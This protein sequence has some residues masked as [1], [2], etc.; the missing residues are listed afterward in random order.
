MAC[1]IS[2]LE[3]ETGTDI[4][5]VGAGPIGIEMALALKSKNFDYLHF[6]AGPLASTISWYSPGTSIFSSPERLAIGEIPFSVYPQLK[7][8]RED[9]LNYLRGVVHQ[10]QP[11]IHTF[12]RIFSV[13]KRSDRTFT[14]L[15][16]PS[17]HGVGGPGELEY[18]SN[19]P[20]PEKENTR[21]VHCKRLILAIGNMHLP[22]VLSI[23]GETLPHVSHFL[24]D[25]H[26]YSGQRVAIVGAKNS[27]AE[28]AIRLCQAH[29]EVTICHR[30]E[31]FDSARVKPWLMPQLRSLQREKRIRFIPFVVPS[32]IEVGSLMLRDLAGKAQVLAC[33]RV[34]LLT[35]YRQN[36]QLFE[37]LGLRLLAETKA[38]LH[39][40]ISMETNVPGV[41][42]AGTAV[43]GT[44]IGGAKAFIE[45]SHIHV[46]KIMAALSG[47]KYTES[48]SSKK[49]LRPEVDWET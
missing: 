13:Q 25:V 28:A 45:T 48:Q 47:T 36:P 12:C 40:P 49:L 24:E 21:T 43:S 42:V 14:C 34:L 8:T 32:R 30:G 31:D 18:A 17:P 22:N 7:A 35:G 27:A 23:P 2:D 41:Y 5:L 9:Y 26:T 38:P 46:D 29:A 11:K 39:D 19:N 10:H 20:S 1:G 44:Q 16:G 15:L 3:L 4:V 33:D 37:Q 6:E